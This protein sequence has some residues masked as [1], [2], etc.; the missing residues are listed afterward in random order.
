MITN[1]LEFVNENLKEFSIHKN[2]AVKFQTILSNIYKRINYKGETVTTN[3]SDNVLNCG[4]F[5]TFREYKDPNQTMILEGANFCKNKLCPMCAWRLHLKN[6]VKFDRVFKELGQGDYYHLVLTIQNLPNINKQFILDFRQKATKF[7][8]TI[9]KIKDFMLSFEITIGKDKT[10]HP[11]YHIIYEKPA[12]KTYTKKYLQTEWAKIVNLGAKWYII[13]N[14]K[15]NKPTISRE[16]TKYILKF[17]GIEP[18]EQILTILSDSLKGVRKYSTSGKFLEA[19][20]KIEQIIDDEKF[21]KM[22]NLQDYQYK[23]L[24]YQ[25]FRDSYNIIMEREN[26]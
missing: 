15:L 21:Q 7:L 26:G 2:Y 11:H 4:N 16:L 19:Q 17:E 25:W 8:R 5:L 9:M 24:F 10:F 18:D 22:I 13:D 23:M 12:N 20:R 3:K 6:S 14:K 1:N